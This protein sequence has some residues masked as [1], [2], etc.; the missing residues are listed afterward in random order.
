MLRSLW[1]ELLIF[2]KDMLM[3]SS[4]QELMLRKRSCLWMVAKLMEMLSKLSSHY[5][6]VRKY[7]HP[8]NLSQVHRKE[9]LQN[10]II[11]VLTLRKMGPSAQERL[12]LL[13]KQHFPQEGVHLC[14]E[15]AHHLGDCLI[16]L[17]AGGQALLSAVVVIH[18]LGAG[19]HRHLEVVLHLLRL[20]DD[21]D[22]LQGAP[23]EESVA[24]LFEDGLLL[25]QDEG[26]HH[27]GDYAVLPED[28]QSA[29]VADPQ[30]GGLDALAQ[31]P[32]HPAGDEAQLGDVGGHL[33]TLA[34][35][36]P[37]GVLGRYQGAAVQGG[38]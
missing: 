32:Y 21:I 34:L 11:P 12:L 10:L 26:H 3:L 17:L 8:L 16:L 35:Q 28:L 22:L 23:L 33:L 30:F 14:L 20:Q 2:Q 38:H 36:V 7:L 24:V 29:G 5:Q 13:G 19:Q 1:I 4:R 27:Q 6:R 25:P 18:R 9:M 31:G 37:E 15:E